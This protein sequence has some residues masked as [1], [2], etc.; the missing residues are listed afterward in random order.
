MTCHAIKGD[1]KAY[2]AERWG[3]VIIDRAEELLG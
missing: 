1:D 2:A 3:K